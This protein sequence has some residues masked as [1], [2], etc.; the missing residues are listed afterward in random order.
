MK[1]GEF[2]EFLKTNSVEGSIVEV[3]KKVSDL[4]INP[5][6]CKQ[7]IFLRKKRGNME[8]N[9]YYGIRDFK[10]SD[11]R[12]GYSNKLAQ[13]LKTDFFPRPINELKIFLSE[14]FI[15]KLEQYNIDVFFPIFWR[16]N[17][18]GLYLIHSTKAIQSPSFS[19]LV[20]SLARALSAAYHIKW[21]ETK[22]DN[23]RKQYDNRQLKMQS[24]Q[25]GNKQISNILKLVRHH[26]STTIVPDLINTLKDILEMEKL[27]YFYEPKNDADEPILIQEGVA[28]SLMIPDNKL[29]KS[30]ADTVKKNTFYDIENINIDSSTAKNWLNSLKKRGLKYIASYP[31]SPQRQGILAWYGKT[32]DTGNM[33]NDLKFLKSHTYDIIENAES[34]ETIEAMSYTDNLTGLANQRYFF[35]RLDEEINRARRYKRKLALIIF[36]IDELKNTND[37]Y[38]HLAGDELLS[39]MGEV[40]KKTIRSIDIIARYGGD[41]FC[42]IMPEADKETCIKFM[43]RLQSKIY[44]KQFNIESINKSIKCTVSLG[45]AIFPDQAEDAKKLLFYADMALLKAKGAG[46]NRF[47]IYSPQM[48]K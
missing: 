45:G 38:G 25:N 8:L 30:V 32:A 27:A 21:H 19:L 14:K 41:E 26:N 46:R 37:K 28:N 39:H 44:Q 10:R 3:A 17:L 9:Y 35:K 16:E 48:N 4:L 23:L 43:R 34:F 40:L 42:I 2:S 6:G 18:Y 5:F 12:I 20:G 15:K 7:I 24:E 31:L 47:F 36:D 13:F 22:Y 33:K 1:P 29:L 11:F